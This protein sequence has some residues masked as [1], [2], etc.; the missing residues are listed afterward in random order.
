ML[1]T[2][3]LLPQ[4]APPGGGFLEELRHRL[5]TLAKSHGQ[6]SSRYEAI[7]RDRR[8]P[9]PQ[10]GDA[11]LRP[12]P[13]AIWPAEQTALSGG[14]RPECRGTWEHPAVQIAAQSGPE[15]L[16]VLGIVVQAT[17]P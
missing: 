7:R 2:L 11:S 6:H 8:R 15:L 14:T 9:R 17:K 4:L 10:H 3:I 5:Q 16:G 12:G 1:I 13:H